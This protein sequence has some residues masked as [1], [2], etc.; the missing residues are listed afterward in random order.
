MPDL[1]VIVLSVIPFVLLVGGV[2]AYRHRYRPQHSPGPLA[3]TPDALWDTLPR[4]PVEGAPPWED[5]P[6]WA[7]PEFPRDGTLGTNSGAGGPGH[8][9]W[10]PDDPWEPEPTRPAPPWDAL[11]ADWERRA[12]TGDVMDAHLA[13]DCAEFMRHQD[14]EAALWSLELADGCAAYVR[15]LAVSL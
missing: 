9:G 10:W 5:M 13:A 4:R 12:D 8:D 7:R 6:E 11:L 1:L 15:E 2:Q 14:Q 3:V